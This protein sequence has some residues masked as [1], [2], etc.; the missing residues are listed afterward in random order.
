MTT[1]QHPGDV[2]RERG[3]SKYEFVLHAWKMY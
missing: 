3:R 1:T 2:I